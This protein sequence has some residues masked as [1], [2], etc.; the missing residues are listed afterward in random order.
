MLSLPRILFII[1]QTLKSG[2]SPDLTLKSGKSPDLTLK[3][4]AKRVAL[5][6]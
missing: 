6:L 2:K 1:K 3:P 5:K 4:L